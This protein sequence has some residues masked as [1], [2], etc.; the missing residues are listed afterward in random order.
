MPAGPT[1]MALLLLWWS[2]S[3]GLPVGAGGEGADAEAGDP[4][5]DLSSSTWYPGGAGSATEGE[6]QVDTT[7]DS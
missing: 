4:R 5:V 7:S 3:S 2:I 1:F 6:G